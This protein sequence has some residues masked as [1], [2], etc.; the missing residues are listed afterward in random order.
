M[1][2]K[3]SSPVNFCFACGG[4]FEKSIIF[5]KAYEINISGNRPE[6]ATA[7]RNLVDWAAAQNLEKQRQ[8]EAFVETKWEEGDVAPGKLAGILR[9]EP[10]RLRDYAQGQEKR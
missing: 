6:A 9:G 7:T 1:W 8:V 3:Y 4:F 10:P 5:R 2:Q